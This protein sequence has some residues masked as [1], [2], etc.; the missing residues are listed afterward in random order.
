[1]KGPTNDNHGKWDCQDVNKNGVCDILVV[2]ITQGGAKT[3]KRPDIFIS[4]LPSTAST[5]I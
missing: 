2:D 1:V 3:I 4:R 5:I